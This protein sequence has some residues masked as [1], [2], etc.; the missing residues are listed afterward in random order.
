MNMF[1]PADRAYD[2]FA[3]KNISELNNINKS[4]ILYLL[5]HSLI[6]HKIN[7][8]VD[9]FYRGNLNRKPGINY[10]KKYIDNILTYLKENGS[11]R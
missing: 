11:T 4:T 1:D 8:I 5:S 6:D 3:Y 9:M 7:T 2:C 10:G